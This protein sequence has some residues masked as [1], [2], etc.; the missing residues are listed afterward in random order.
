MTMVSSGPISL[1]G[2]A[3]TS[4]TGPGNVT[5][6]FISHTISA[7][8]FSL[9]GYN[10]ATFSGQTMSPDNTTTVG[11]GTVITALEWISTGGS[12]L[13]LDVTGATVDSGFTAIKINGTTFLRT[14]ATFTSGT[15][16]TWAGVGN[17][18]PADGS[19]VTV[20][21]TGVPGQLITLNQSV[22]I[23]LTSF[24]G[25]NPAGTTAITINDVH[26]R[27]LAAI[28]SGPISLSDFYGK[29]GPFTFTYTLASGN[30]LNNFDLNSA[31]SGAGWDGVSAIIATININGVL[32]SSSPLTYAFES[33]SGYASGSTIQINIGAGG[34]ITGCGG[35]QGTGSPSGTGG[36]AIHLTYS[37]KIVNS[38]ILQGGGGAGAYGDGG[39][40][41][42]GAGYF[43]GAGFGGSP[44]AILNSGSGYAHNPGSKTKNGGAGGGWVAQAYAHST[45]GVGNGSPGT[46]NNEG[47]LGGGAQPGH[48]IVGIANL[49]GGSTLGTTRGSAI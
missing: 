17:P 22:E 11:G 1:G 10:P 27:A 36:S 49:A 15:G 35:S 39:Y 7:K 30:F 43:I 46:G 32:G 14:S 37:T 3:T 16:W 21:F 29:T 44:A 9:S 19:T 28:P 8:F 23:E 40:N 26:A 42:G 5:K 47:P 6:T 25:N 45:N 2:N 24:Y 41:G 38:G 31:L 48:Y 12:N 20:I 13:T 18:F 34:Y 4:S 33:G